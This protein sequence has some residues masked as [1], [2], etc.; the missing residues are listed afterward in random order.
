MGSKEQ[1]VWI[2]EGR[3]VALVERVEPERDRADMKDPTDPVG[4]VEF[5]V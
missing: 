1:V 4:D 5:P 3:I 2:D